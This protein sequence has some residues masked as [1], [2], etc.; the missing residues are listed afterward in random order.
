[1]NYKNLGKSSLK[2]SQICLGTNNFGGQVS[3]KAS[4][5]IINKALDCGIN[6][7]DTANTYTGGKSEEMIGECTDKLFINELST[8]SQRISCFLHMVS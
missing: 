6:L 7:V 4:I 8:H 1:M 5:E 3:E 2:V